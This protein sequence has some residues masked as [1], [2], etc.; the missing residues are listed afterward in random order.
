M[1]DPG[2]DP[3]QRFSA[4]VN[5]Y[6]KYRPGYPAELVQLLRREIVLTPAWIVADIGSGTGISAEPF[7]RHGNTV[8]GVEPN[9]D[10][11]GAAERLLHRYG[12]FRSIDGSAEATALQG[13]SVDLIICAQAFHWFNKSLAAGEFER[14]L[15]PGGYVAIVF[16]DR[17]TETSALLAGYDRLLRA[18]GTDYKQVS[19]TTTTVEQL[20]ALFGTTFQRRASPNQQ[21]FDFE[22][23]RGRAMSASYVPL[24]GQPGHA[25]I[26]A[27]LRELFDAHQQDGRV[28]F[29]YETEV[30][31]GRIS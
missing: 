29:E 17:K 2:L 9:A 19:R 12:N 22:G 5:D 26:L 6:I 27:G 11:R 14:I 24:P 20:G 25:E 21:V 3:T 10:M 23:L 30:F 16:N 15:R 31:Y 28:T 18:Y 1:S 4:R 7:L 13:N 8:F